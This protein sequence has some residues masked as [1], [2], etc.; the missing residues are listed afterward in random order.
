MKGKDPD[1]MKRG[2]FGKQVLWVVIAVFLVGA[3]VVLLPC[4]LAR[5]GAV[6]RAFLDSRPSAAPR[7]LDPLSSWE[8]AY[9][10]AA[11]VQEADG[12]HTFFFWPDR[13]FGVLTHPDYRGQHETK[14]S[15]EWAVTSVVI[16]LQLVIASR[17]PLMAAGARAHFTSLLPLKVDGRPLTEMDVGQ[18]RNLYRSSWMV[19]EDCLELSSCPVPSL[20]CCVTRVYLSQGRP[21]MIELR[22]QSLLHR[23]E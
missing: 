12:G 3:F 7:V 13:G 21:E 23:Y 18:L 17:M 4:F 22:H 10:E 9:G 20:G 14:P 2:G 19:G 5:H 16:P 15:A 1:T 8:A 11:T 6:G